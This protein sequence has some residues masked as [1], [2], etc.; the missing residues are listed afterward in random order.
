MYSA[1]PA[2][3]TESI[4]L[5]DEWL[6]PVCSPEYAR[7]KKLR[8]AEYDNLEIC[9]LL[10]DNKAW[11]HSEYFSEWEYWA[12][13]SGIKHLNTNSGYSFDRLELTIIAARSG[14]GVA[15]GRN[16][17]LASPHISV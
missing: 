16:T 2:P 10:H 11:P 5:M 8:D 13:K 14:L 15:L 7:E 12:E 1:G 4:S 3:G 17:M 9:L 6:M